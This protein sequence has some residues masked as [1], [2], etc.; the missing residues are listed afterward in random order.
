[1][2]PPAAAAPPV[3]LAF[4]LLCRGRDGTPMHSRE[5]ILDHYRIAVRKPN[6]NTPGHTSTG[7]EA[8]PSRIR[9]TQSDSQLAALYQ[10]TLEAP[11]PQDMLRLL[12]KI[13]ESH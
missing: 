11:I 6:S 12:E 1:M 2:M 10:D 7:S 5:L 8:R 3:M 4:P 13:A 9:Q